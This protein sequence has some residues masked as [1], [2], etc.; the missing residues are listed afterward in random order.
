MNLYEIDAPENL[1]D[2]SLGEERLLPQAGQSFAGRHFA[3]LLL[4]AEPRR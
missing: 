2:P 1:Y 3:R 4:K